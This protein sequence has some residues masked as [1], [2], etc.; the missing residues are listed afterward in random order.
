[1]QV[2]YLSLFRGD[3]CL[4]LPGILRM[5]QDY[6]DLGGGSGHLALV[7]WLDLGCHHEN[8]LRGLGGQVSDRLYLPRGDSVETPL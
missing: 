4:F 5:L 2:E 6:V 8:A 1:M 3:L 7:R